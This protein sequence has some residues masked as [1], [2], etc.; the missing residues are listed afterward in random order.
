MDSALAPLASKLRYPIM[1]IEGFGNLPMNSSAYKLLSTSDRREI[2]INTEAWDPIAGT[3]PEVVI[4]LPADRQPGLPVETVSYAV[5]QKVRLVGIDYITVGGGAIHEDNRV[6]HLT[7]LNGGISILE[8]LNLK[9]VE[10][11]RY[12]LFAL[13]LRIRKGDAGPCRAVIRPLT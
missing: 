13:P 1:I 8:G 7:L 5:G 6:I 3:R 10:P 4:P 9:G 12:E 2:A 11:G